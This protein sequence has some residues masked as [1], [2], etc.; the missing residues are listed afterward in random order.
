VST[1]LIADAL[2]LPLLRE[3]LAEIRGHFP[4]E[5]GDEAEIER[6][7]DVIASCERNLGLRRDDRQPLAPPP[8]DWVDQ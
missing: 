6:L 4:A 5:P 7:T 3:R 1:Y 2:R 8:L